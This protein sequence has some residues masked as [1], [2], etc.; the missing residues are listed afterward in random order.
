M[1]KKEL[2]KI[3]KD[4]I[5]VR[6]RKIESLKSNKYFGQEV[7]I[8]NKMFEDA[9]FSHPEDSVD[10]FTPRIVELESEIAQIE[11]DVLKIKSE[12]KLKEKELKGRKYE[13][14]SN[15]F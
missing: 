14:N 7:N 2:D 5:K 3:L 8:V 10:I 11:K 6:Q 9:C 15:S 1:T 4:K 12:I 13:I